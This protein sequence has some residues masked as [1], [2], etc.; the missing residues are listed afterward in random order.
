MENR[1]YDED[2]TEQPSRSE[3]K[4]SEVSASDVTK[5]ETETQGDPDVLER[6]NL[7]IK[8]GLEILDKAFDKVNKYNIPLGII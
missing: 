8:M 1:V 7:A 4:V 2:E 3:S 5:G 6:A